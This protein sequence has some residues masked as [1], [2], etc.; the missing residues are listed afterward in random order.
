MNN[1]AT[2]TASLRMKND[3]GKNG[4]A[5]EM[6][7]RE[8]VRS[9]S[10]RGQKPTTGARKPDTPYFLVFSESNK[11]VKSVLSSLRES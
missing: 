9:F 5:S 8:V 10:T 4:A 11:A 6:S 2:A 1:K 7:T 3:V